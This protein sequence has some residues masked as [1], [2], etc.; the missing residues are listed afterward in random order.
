MT[1]TPLATVTPRIRAIR[2]F[3]CVPDLPMRIVLASAV[4]LG[5]ADVDV[6]TT[7]GWVD[8]ASVSNTDV[9]LPGIQISKHLDHEAD[10]PNSAVGEADHRGT[11]SRSNIGMVFARTPTA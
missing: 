7:G 9:V 5:R 11:L 3:F 2:V 6:V 10:V 4:T 1:P 8:T